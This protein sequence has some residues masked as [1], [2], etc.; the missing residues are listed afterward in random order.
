MPRR[1]FQRQKVYD[2]E[3]ESPWGRDFSSLAGMQ[4]YVDRITRTR[5]WRARVPSRYWHITVES[6]PASPSEVGELSFNRR[7][8]KIFVSEKPNGRPAPQ[9]EMQLV[10]EL[11]HFMVKGIGHGPEYVRALLDLTRR[12]HSKRTRS[13]IMSEKLVDKGAAVKP[14]GR[15][16]R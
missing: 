11:A 14:K 1:D 12:F 5:W 8:R 2:A 16:S 13:R 3:D 4:S 7:S 6:Y 9:S 15:G 10:H